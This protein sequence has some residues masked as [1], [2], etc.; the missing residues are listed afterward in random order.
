MVDVLL[1]QPPIRDFYLT[2]K[3]TIPYGL[4]CIAAG[5]IEAGF[6]V[7]I[8]DALAN[9]KSRILPLPPEMSYLRPYYE[10]PDQSPFALFHD[11]KHFGCSFDTIGQQVREAQPFLV[12][13]SSL[14][15]AYA[16]EAIKTAQVVRASKP[17]CKIILGGHH[18]T[19]L[20]ERVMQSSAVDFVMRGE[21]EHSMPMIAKAIQN[22]SDFSQIPGLVYRQSD[23]SVHL[24]EPAAMADPGN[25]PL[26]AIDL[27]DRRH[28]R[29]SKKISTVIVA[30]RG[31]PLKCTYC[32]IGATS[33]LSYRRRSVESVMSEIE[34]AVKH[35]AVGFID[36][37]DENLS[38]DRNWFLA[39]LT[40]I[41][42]RMKAHP[43]ELRAMNGLLPSSLDEQVIRAMKTAGFKALNLSLGTTAKAQLQ[44]FQRPDVSGAFERVLDL[45]ELYD[46]KAV[47]YIIAGAPFQKADDSL[48]DLI[49]LAQKRV[50]IGTSVFYPAPGSA[51]YGLC[52]A[53]GLLPESFSCMR[54]SALPL[55][56]ATTRIES[57]TLLRL[58]RIINFMKSLIDSGRP[59]PDPA[60]AADYLD[61]SN[62]RQKIGEKLLQF[63][64]HDAR[65]RGVSP[66][67]EVF[68][69]KIDLE[70]SKKF[71]ARLKLIRIRGCEKRQ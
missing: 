57:I 13:I 31:C 44:R 40:A 59:L 66:D 38:L 35:Y 36:F 39:L 51:D 9:S 45:A 60:P 52:A 18:P 26:P 69:H 27:L 64:L 65:I 10:R 58:S 37:E 12:G 25:Y 7:K 50:L 42:K 17:D 24:S 63:F 4:A 1:I 33:P 55:S 68:E 34:R 2:A 15:T 19:A 62:N 22:G 47:G 30:S 54:S 71:L 29:R 21:G 11:Y 5:L 48:T 8:L 6:S 53:M 28:Y 3:R 46:L 67:G 32:S 49:Y 70:L 61:H 56:H 20:P 43:L 41:T 16:D 23:G 14:F